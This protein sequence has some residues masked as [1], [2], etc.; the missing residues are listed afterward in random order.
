MCLIV[1]VCMNLCIAVHAVPIERLMKG[2]WPSMDE[3]ADFG[4]SETIYISIELNYHL[5]RDAK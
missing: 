5:E 1:C 2:K 3:K 4:K